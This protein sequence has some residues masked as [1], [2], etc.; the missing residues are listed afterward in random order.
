VLIT[1]NNWDFWSKWYFT[2]L[3]TALGATLESLVY[4]DLPLNE[5]PLKQI[6]IPSTLILSCHLCAIVRQKWCSCLLPTR[7]CPLKE[8]LKHT[9]SDVLQ[10]SFMVTLLP[11][12]AYVLHDTVPAW[13]LYNTQVNS[14]HLIGWLIVTCRSLKVLTHGPIVQFTFGHF[15]LM[16]GNSAR[17]PCI[18]Y[19]ST[20]TQY[21]SGTRLLGS[22]VNKKNSV[23]ETDGIMGIVQILLNLQMMNVIIGAMDAELNGTFSSFTEWKYSYHCTHNIHYLYTIELPLWSYCGT[24]ATMVYQ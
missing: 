19:V 7:E 11:E 10:S 24:C 23:H 18:H 13:V 8:L 21:K 14:S 5:P 20:Y 6:N 12:P 16:N 1:D 15:V 3:K 9:H 4:T 17:L 2:L 22:E